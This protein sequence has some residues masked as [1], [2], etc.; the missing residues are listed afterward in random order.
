[1][2]KEKTPQKIVLKQRVLILLFASALFLIL[3]IAFNAQPAYAADHPNPSNNVAPQQI[4]PD[5]QENPSNRIQGWVWVY[6]SNCQPVSGINV[7]LYAINKT[8]GWP[9]EA[10]PVQTWSNGYFYF[11]NGDPRFMDCIAPNQ[12]CY[13]SVNGWQYNGQTTLGSFCDNPAWGQWLGKVTTDNRGYGCFCPI[14]L[15]PAAVVNVPA[16]AIFSNTKYATVSYEMENGHYVSHSLTFSVPAT[17]TSVGYEQDTA[18]TYGMIFSVSPNCGAKISMRHYAASYWDDTASPRGVKKTGISGSNL[19]WW[20]DFLSQS[21]YLSTSNTDVVSNHKESRVDCGLTLEGYYYEQGSTKWSVTQ[22]V[23]FALSYLA[24]GT[25]LKL[26]VT[27]TTSDSNKVK[28]KIDRSNDA[29]PN[30]LT[31]WLYTAGALCDPS[32]HQGGMEFHV[33]DVSGAG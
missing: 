27:V 1:M 31:F 7:Y 10:G 3:V 14:W 25:N 16:A 2:E 19:N 18:V 4:I 33:W 30:T 9:M 13:I 26:D 28:F 22:G 11:E 21:E 5:P 29:N 17:G 20:W 32:N 8:N 24:Y 6:G 23:P 12:V 15:S